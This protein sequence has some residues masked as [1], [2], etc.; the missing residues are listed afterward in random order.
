MKHQYDQDQLR[1]AISQSTSIRQALI[2]LGVSPQGGNYKIIHTAVKKWDIDISHF[3]G[4]S[5]AKGKALGARVPVTD[6]L[7]PG[8][9]IGSDR[10]RKRLLREGIFEPICSCCSLSTWNNHPIPLE[11]DHIDGQHDNNELSN[12]RLL[13][14]N[15]HAQTHTYRGKNKKSLQI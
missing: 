9:N 5:H 7:R 12:L 3:T 14:P 6:Y 8:T 2:H 10:L 11:L 13:C 1:T 4:Q 15:C